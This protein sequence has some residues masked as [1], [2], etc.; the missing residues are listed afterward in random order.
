MGQEE[1]FKEIVLI[2]DQETSFREG[3]LV[4]L[5]V[6]EEQT[7]NHKQSP[8]MNAK[9]SVGDVIEVSK[10]V[11]DIIKDSKAS[12]ATAATTSRILSV[13]DDR[14][15]DYEKAQNFKSKEVTYKLDNFAGVNCYKVKFKVAG[16]YRAVNPDFGG[17]WIPNVH[18]TFSE[19]HANFPWI[20]NG[21]AKIDEKYVSNMGTKT[22]PIPQLV[23]NVKIK[24]EAK[25]GFTVESHER[26]FEF[27][28]NAQDG[29]DVIN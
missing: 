29:V 24:T 23:L 15:E 17:Q 18:I 3:T 12:A 5:Q 22:D 16:T 4:E 19:C 6:Q 13:K 10:F 11:W 28:L 2:D 9:A 25:F 8:L 21:E 7:L 20:I 14:W 26:T 1:R 27:T